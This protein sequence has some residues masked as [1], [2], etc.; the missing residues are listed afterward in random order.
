MSR[1]AVGRLRFREDKA[2]ERIEKCPPATPAVVPVQLRCAAEIPAV[3]HVGYP[4]S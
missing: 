2:A 4:G 3:E 1:M